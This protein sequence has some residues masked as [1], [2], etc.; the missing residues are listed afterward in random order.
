MTATGWKW[1]RV[2]EARASNWF[3]FENASI[4]VVNS[5]ILKQFRRSFGSFSSQP[6]SEAVAEQPEL[7]NLSLSSDAD[8]SD[9]NGDAEASRSDTGTPSVLLSGSKL[10][11][12]KISWSGEED[13][14]VRKMV[15][16]HGTG[17]WATIASALP[18]RN[19]K[20]CRERWHNHLDPCIRKDTWTPDE[21]NVLIDAQKLHGNKWAE[22][23]KLLPGRTDNAIKNHWNSTLRRTLEREGQTPTPIQRRTS[24]SASAASPTES[25]VVQVAKAAPA[26]SFLSPRTPKAPLHPTPKLCSLAGVA[27]QIATRKKRKMHLHRIDM[28][29]D[30]SPAATLASLLDG[31]ILIDS[32][33]SSAPTSSRRRLVEPSTIRTLDMTL[34]DS[35]S[36]LPAMSAISA[37]DPSFPSEFPFPTLDVCT[38][39]SA[40]H[41]MAPN[42]LNAIMPANVPQDPQASSSDSS[43]M[44]FA[45]SNVG[46][47]FSS[48]PS[49]RSCSPPTSS[50]LQKRG[51]VDCSV[52]V[53]S[54]TLTEEGQRSNTDTPVRAHFD[55]L[56][57]A[58]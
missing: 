51:I 30:V 24:S 39:F 33:F 19:G 56:T 14:M 31:S 43:G 11:S 50:I 45:T 46:D 49:A 36:F 38:L 16:L 2:E 35:L 20:Q 27:S 7:G 28:D 54:P 10:R 52:R 57:V 25:A 29:D 41:C 42:F 1:S 40:V 26:A 32:G 4:T 55:A 37:M 6:M 47:A 23:A 13:A 8:F 17:R 53:A 34:Q 58:D 18:G 12:V 44:D 15:Q 48:S 3:F 5:D 9:D 22:I 21:D